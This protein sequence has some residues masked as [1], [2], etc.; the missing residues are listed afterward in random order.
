MTVDTGVDLYES[1]L[2]LGTPFTSAISIER[3]E[4]G[5]DHVAWRLTSH[6]SIMKPLKE[7]RSKLEDSS[8]KNYTCRV[9]L[10]L[11]WSIHT[12]L[13]LAWKCDPL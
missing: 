10:E 3:F 1:I 9:K 6:V 12:S 13:Q 8:K 2:I 5:L 11:T 4:V 7:L